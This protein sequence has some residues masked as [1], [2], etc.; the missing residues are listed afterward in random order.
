MEAIKNGHTDAMK[1]LIQHGANVALTDS[2]GRTSLHYA[3]GCHGSR[4]VLSCLIE[5]GA[6][7]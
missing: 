3:C 4:E 2:N 5:N 1:V 6:A 7:L